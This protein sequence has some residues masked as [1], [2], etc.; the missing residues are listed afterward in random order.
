[1]TN[2]RIAEADL[3]VLA[4]M[5]ASARIAEAD[6]TVLARLTAGA[7][8]S[9]ADITAL[10]YV[11]PCS[12]QRAQIWTITRRD[13]AALRF[14]TRDV[15]LEFGGQTYRACGS[16]LDSASESGSELGSVGSIEMTGIF[17][18]DAITAAD[19]MDGLY[20]DAYVEAWVVSWGDGPD[21][22]TPFRIAAGWT[23]KVT[24]GEANYTAE[25]LGP[26]ARLQQTALVDFYIPGC[27]WRV[28][29]DGSQCPVDVEARKIAGVVVTDDS[30]ASRVNFSEAD[31]GGSIW[32][33]GKVRWLTGRNE[34]V[35]CQTN[36]VDFDAG[37]ITLWD[38]APNPPQGGDTFDLLPGCPR[39]TDA[40]KLYGA[41]ESFGGFPDVPGPDS[42]QSNADSLF[43]GANG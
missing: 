40:C 18:D 2:A 27:R 37:V 22:A 10:A 32:N 19:I 42:L 30:V 33:G 1:M 6:L 17:D 12:T 5:T 21:P 13:G 34:G 41:F 8:I 35:V 14:T 15:D 36:T 43:T 26:G 9:E 38:I 3:T 20:D 24:R 31:P 4:Q 16:V 23:G 28:F 7:E 29:G 39:T 11:A 25:V